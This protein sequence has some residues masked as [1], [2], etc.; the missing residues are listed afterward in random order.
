VPEAVPAA[1][2]SPR[3][4][5]IQDLRGFAALSVCWYHYVYY[6][7]IFSPALPH[8]FL[9]NTAQ[10]GWLGV[11][12]FFVISGFILPYSLFR[13][14]YRPGVGNFGRFLWKRLSRLEPPYLISIAIMIGVMSVP[15]LL[16]WLGGSAPKF[17][18][19]Q[20]LLHFGYLNSFFNQGWY[21]NPVY[22]TL[23]IEFQYY[24]L[25]GLMYPL[26]SGTRRW[27]RVFGWCLLTGIAL[28]DHVS[29][30]GHWLFLFMLG[31]AMFQYRAGI[32][33]KSEF[34]CTFLLAAA[35]SLA[36]LGKSI[37]LVGLAACVVILFVRRSNPLTA[38]L[39][40]LSYSFYLIHLPIGGVVFRILQ[41]WG[42]GLALRLTLVAIA[43]AVS[44]G[45]AHLLYR[46]VER[47]CQRYA[48]SLRFEKT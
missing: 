5:V 18:L 31:F 44:L 47:P 1:G 12:I 9:G 21:L 10:Y 36:T 13:A 33:G 6:N 2:S 3:I 45:V 7:G 15:H 41:S 24:L 28:G 20:V 39:G 48:G 29:S 26:I 19:V 46:W 37:T 17:T 30:L 22:W 35:A 34:G 23:G 4:D 38:W 40:D 27:I 11:Q 32:V 8:G 16:P 43:L 25:I 14:G 42:S